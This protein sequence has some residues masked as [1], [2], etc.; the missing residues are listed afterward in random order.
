MASGIAHDFNNLLT[1]VMANASLLAEGGQ[2]REA[3]AILSAA[4]TGAEL[5]RRLLAV[6]RR[7]PVQ[8]VPVDV[9][10]VVA[11]SASLLQR[12][13]DTAVSLSTDLGARSQALADPHH[14]QQILL[15]LVINARDALA[16]GGRVRIETRSEEH[17]GRPTVAVR[18]I[19]DGAGMDAETTARAFEPFFT[20]KAPGYG[21][22]LG[23]SMVRGIVEQLDGVIDLHSTP[24]RGTTVSLWFPVAEG[25]EVASQASVAGRGEATGVVLLV[26][27]EPAVRALAVRILRRAGFEVVEAEGPVQARAHLAAGPVDVVVSDIAMPH[28]GGRQVADDIERT[29]P[30]TPLVLMTGYDPRE[31]WIIYP[32][33]RKPFAPR[34]LVEAVR[35]ARDRAPTAAVDR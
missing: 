35:A 25:N 22:G 15:N 34:A 17:D 19:D 26:E 30:G 14:L 18:V 33:V 5:T 1:V 21:S 3:E 9:N 10:R 4:E 24:G 27:D 32:V 31:D 28:G 8:A 6:G 12:V 29:Q 23:L 7:A 20:T 16:P 2:S 11:D 13:L